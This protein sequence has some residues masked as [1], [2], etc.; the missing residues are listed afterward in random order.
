MEFSLG[1]EV[2][3][4]PDA[5]L[6]MLTEMPDEG[7]LVLVGLEGL[8]EVSRDG[9]GR[10]HDSSGGLSMKPDLGICDDLGWDDFRDR[11]DHVVTEGVEISERIDLCH[12][13]NKSPNVSLG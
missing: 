11:A 1:Q 2:G 9:T 8:R 5:S 13:C 4:L 12:A 7:M 10:M 6:R 3:D